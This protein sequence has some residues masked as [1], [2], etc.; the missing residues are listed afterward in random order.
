MVE[1]LIN[2]SFDYWYKIIKEKKQNE[3][4]RKKLQLIFMI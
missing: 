4:V 1:K 2:K 3:R